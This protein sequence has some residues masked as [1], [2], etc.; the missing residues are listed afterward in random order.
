VKF[1]FLGHF[2]Q[3]SKLFTNIYNILYHKYPEKS[4]YD[5]NFFA[6]KRSAFSNLICGD[7]YNTK[8]IAL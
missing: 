5:N 3:E 7:F 1:N 2:L 8:P 4:I 6:T